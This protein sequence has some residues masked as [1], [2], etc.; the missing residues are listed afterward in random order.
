MLADTF[1]KSMS[2]QYFQDFFN[3][4]SGDYIVTHGTG[5]TVAVA[6][7]S[8]TASGGWLKLPTAAS[9]N[10]Y[11]SLAI[12]N[13]ILEV[14]VD[15]TLSPPKR[16]PIAAE[17]RIK[18]SETAANSSSWFFGLTDTLTTG[19][20]S[21]AGAPPSSFSGAVIYKAHGSSTIQFITSNGSSQA[22]NTNIGTFVSGTPLLLSILVNPNDGVTARVTA[23]LNGQA[24]LNLVPIQPLSLT[25]ASLNPM[26][27]ACGIV[28]STSSAETLLLDYWGY[29]FARN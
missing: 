14:S 24:D 8:G 28:A 16:L 25:L 9:A 21:S 1:Q 23:E 29:E 26:Y 7:A 15:N 13:P 22:K 10:D 17:A 27:M 20:L 5:G 6:T 11:E 4:T 12:A 3:Y 2:G 19:F 18:I